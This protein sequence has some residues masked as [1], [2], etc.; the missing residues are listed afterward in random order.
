MASKFEMVL[1]LAKLDYFANGIGL[2]F[3]IKNSNF[4][5]KD[6][7]FHGEIVLLQMLQFPF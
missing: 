7:F 3:Q 6:T 2:M 4:V 5:W 1:M